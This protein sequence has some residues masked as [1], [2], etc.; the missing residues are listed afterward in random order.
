MVLLPQR[1]FSSVLGWKQVW[2]QGCLWLTCLISAHH[3]SF[4]TQAGARL[5][6]PVWEGKLLNSST[7]TGGK[8]RASA[9]LY[10]LEAQSLP[11]ASCRA[12]AIS[13]RDLEEVGSK[14]LSSLEPLGLIPVPCSRRMGSVPSLSPPCWQCPRQRSPAQAVPGLDVAA[15]PALCLPAVARHGA[16]GSMLTQ[17]RLRLRG[18]HGRQ[19]G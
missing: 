1:P 14:S 15:G 8:S 11:S 10:P 9:D 19:E 7:L 4:N 17:T 18:C 2:R 6:D 12:S 13:F 5:Q 16:D 3:S